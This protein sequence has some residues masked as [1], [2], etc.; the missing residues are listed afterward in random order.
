MYV[1][2]MYLGCRY[3]STS[4]P[5]RYIIMVY[6]IADDL[7]LR[8]EVCFAVQIITDQRTGNDFSFDNNR[9]YIKQRKNNGRK[10]CSSNNNMIN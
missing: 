3:T 9:Y 6:I 1:R 5:R 4:G 7:L 10:Y 2:P 8:G